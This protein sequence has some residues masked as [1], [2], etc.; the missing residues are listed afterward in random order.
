MEVA[1]Q[2]EKPGISTCWREYRPT[3][4]SPWDLRRVV[5]LHRRAGFAAT[6]EEIQ[7]DLQEGPQASI[8]R[9]MNGTTCEKTY[10]ED[11]ERMSASIAEAAVRSNQPE[12]LKAWWLFRMLFTTDPL[13]EK[14]TLLW[15][16]HFA[17]SN[18]K[19]KDL[20][21]M[22]QQNDLFRSLARAPFGK[23]LIGILHDP[24]LLLWLDAPSNHKV[25]PNE[26]LAREL[27]ELFTLGIGH[28]NETDVKEA[29]RALTGWTV[30]DDRFSFRASQHD[31]G[32]K[33]ILNQRRAWKGDE[34]VELLLDQR[35]TAQRLAGRLCQLF[36]GEGAAQPAD[37]DAL[38]D[39]LRTH[40]LDIDWA[41]ETILRSEL[42]FADQNIRQRVADPA[43]CIIGATRA[44][45]LVDP[46]PQ[47]IILT[48][49]MRQFGQDLFYPPNV[50][51]WNGG[52]H[53]L[54]T[55]ALISRANF[56]TGL[57]RGQFS[58]TQM[59][60]NWS[61]FAAKHGRSS[62]PEEFVTFLA[63]L[64]LGG[65]PNPGWIEGIVNSVS[66]NS[67][68]RAAVLQQ[69]VAAVLASPEAQLN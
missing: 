32:Q 11:F 50:G 38:A 30:I 3:K 37:I 4:K 25:H 17:T 8:D 60:P 2:A 33:T 21:L 23:L 65:E 61:D 18:Q 7:R 64:L 36:L 58:S 1:L 62:S 59:P 12:R 44:L 31:A 67:H 51:G 56:A 68:S 39:G 6:W 16:N 45:E 69:A 13:T 63:D 27:M 19:L 46:P 52:R 15:H 43:E 22:R 14:L 9:V 66:S 55:S 28:F 29:A 34:L 24:A 47:T 5:H 10:P 26:N 42:F 35:G 53:W 41:T 57:S 40:D 49:W 20:S 48:D 54:R